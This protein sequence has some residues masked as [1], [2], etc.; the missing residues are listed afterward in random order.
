MCL[1][2]LTS[3]CVV[4][5]LEQMSDLSPKWVKF[6]RNGTNT[7]GTFSDPI[8]VAYILAHQA[9]LAQIGSPWFVNLQ[10]KQQGDTR[11]ITAF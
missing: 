8:L 6:A 1:A 9:N 7:G 5:C 3:V 4:S 10:M 2:R 11:E